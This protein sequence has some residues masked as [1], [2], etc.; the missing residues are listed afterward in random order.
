MRR[1]RTALA[2]LAAGLLLTSCGNDTPTAED[3]TPAPETSAST[4]TEEPDEQP[5][6]QET[7]DSSEK[8]RPTG[9]FADLTFKGDTAKP[10]GQ[11]VEIEVGK[12]LTLRIDSDRAGELHVH[13][14]PE[15]EISFPPGQ[16]ERKLT[17]EQ[18]GVVDVEDHDTGLVLLQLEVR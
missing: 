10:N 15:Q 7:E 3:P 12:P 9:P 18:P 4:P 2:V 11:R 17:I 16:S 8:P 14:T 6:E 13:A 5:T 1:T